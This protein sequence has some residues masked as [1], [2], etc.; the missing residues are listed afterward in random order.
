VGV[1][2]IIEW[3]QSSPLEEKVTIAFSEAIEQSSLPRSLLIGNGFSIAQAGGQFSYGSLLEKAG[4][5]PNNPIKNVFTTLN[6]VDFELVMQ[7]LQ[8]AAQIEDAYGATNRADLFRKGAAD[9]RE[10]LIHAVTRLSISTNRPT[11]IILPP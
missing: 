7:A 6:T 9:V 4:L 5:Q 2:Q 11:A 3:I 8:H 10:A 1:H